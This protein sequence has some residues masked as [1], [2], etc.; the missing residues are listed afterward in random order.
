M[1]YNKSQNEL[2]LKRCSDSNCHFIYMYYCFVYILDALLFFSLLVIGIFVCQFPPLLPCPFKFAQRYNSVIVYKSHKWGMKKRPL[3]FFLESS[4][5]ARLCVYSSRKGW[6]Q[7]CGACSLLQRCLVCHLTVDCC[8]ATITT[9]PHTPP[10]PNPTD[11]CSANRSCYI[12]H[13]KNARG[14]QHV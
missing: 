11:P 6:A 8:T 13:S 3:G 5:K 4:S 9:P 12:F 10:P 7:G 1:F 2:R 14:H